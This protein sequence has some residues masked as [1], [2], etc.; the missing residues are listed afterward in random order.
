MTDRLPETGSEVDGPL[1]QYIDMDV[2]GVVP[3][4]Q[5]HAVEARLREVRDEGAARLTEAMTQ[6]QRAEKAEA[7]RDRER[8]ARHAAEKLNAADAVR[9]RTNLEARIAEA[10]ARVAELE[11][12]RSSTDIRVRELEEALRPFATDENWEYDDPGDDYPIEH[13]WVGPRNAVDKARQ[14]LEK[15]RL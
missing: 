14:A 12:E 5:L 15:E 1:H 9:K 3:V 10:E 7:E 11:A 13:T 6:L 4:E 8:E 2:Y